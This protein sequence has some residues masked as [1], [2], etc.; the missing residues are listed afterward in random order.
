ML[1]IF[2]LYNQYADQASYFAICLQIYQAADHRNPADVYSTWQSLFDFE[3]GVIAEQGEK[4]T[5]RP[6]EHIITTV[7]ELA[8]RLQLSDNIFAVNIVV[9]I[10]E[11]YAFENQRDVGPPTWTMDLLIDVGLPYESILQ[12]LESM[13]YND[14]Q[15]FHGNNRR[16]IANHM[17]YLIKRWFEHC[18]RTNTRLFGGDEQ[19]ADVS[20]MLLMLV[21][22]GLQPPEVGDANELRQKIARVIR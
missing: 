13:F 5:Q 10:L 22:N 15:P 2:Q 18:V 6:Y 20:Q 4:A 14:E 17:V 3:H 9:P 7:T 16:V 11:K 21:Q 1:T 19:A 12:I 8:H